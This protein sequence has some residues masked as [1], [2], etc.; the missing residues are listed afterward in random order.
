MVRSIL[1]AHYRNVLVCLANKKRAADIKSR[2]QEVPLQ[3]TSGLY[4]FGS[5]VQQSV[6]EVIESDDRIFVAGY[7]E[8]QT[9]FQAANSEGRIR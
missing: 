5:W 4:Y 1:R 8:S 2:S 7:L 9:C 6:G 3:I